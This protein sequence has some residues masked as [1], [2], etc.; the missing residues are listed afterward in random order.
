MWVQYSGRHFVK[1]LFIYLLTLC[2]KLATGNR[3][4]LGQLLRNHYMIN[5]WWLVGMPHGKF[6]KFGPR[7]WHLKHSENTFCKK[8]RF[9]NTV[10]ING[11]KL[12][13]FNQWYYYMSVICVIC[14]KIFTVYQNY[15]GAQPPPPPLVSATG[16][17]FIS[18]ILYPYF[19]YNSYSVFI[20]NIISGFLTVDCSREEIAI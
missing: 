14:Y 19:I 17:V 18:A 10:L 9:Q 4:S 7:K 20:I 13:C 2:L 8:L 5:R 6:L 11:I 15:R 3:N 1:Y 16:T 12:Q